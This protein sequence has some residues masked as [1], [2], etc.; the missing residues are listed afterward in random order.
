MTHEPRP[1]HPEPVPV[2]SSAETRE[3]PGM[4]NC[5]SLIF[6]QHSESSAELW[7]RINPAKPNDLARK[8]STPANS[9]VSTSSFDPTAPAIPASHA[10]TTRL[11]L[12]K[13]SD[14]RP[15]DRRD[16][17]PAHTKPK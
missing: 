10:Q 15:A 11:E 17:Q 1:T 3:L 16:V 5:Y 4:F 14:L 7:P 12:L 9:L 2:R 6:P 8:D 13:T